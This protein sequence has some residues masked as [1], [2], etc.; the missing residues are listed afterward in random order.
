MLRAVFFL[1][2]F[3]Q[4]ISYIAPA[5]VEKVYRAWKRLLYNDLYIITA[6]KTIEY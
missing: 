2:K 5:C 1:L 6:W 4:R 3:E